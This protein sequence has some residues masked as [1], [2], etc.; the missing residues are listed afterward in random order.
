[1]DCRRDARLP[2]PYIPRLD[3]L[4]AYSKT[5]LR[6]LLHHTYGPRHVCTHLLF[7]SLTANK[8]HYLALL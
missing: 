7:L 1:M 6:V 3:I 8:T 5:L 4:G 2:R